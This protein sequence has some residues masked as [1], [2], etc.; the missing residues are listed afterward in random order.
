MVDLESEEQKM[1]EHEHAGEGQRATP[2][3]IAFQSLKTLSKDMKEHGVPDRIDRSVLTNFSGS[4]G[5]QIITA[6]KF[7]G[8]TKPDN[9]TTDRLKSLVDSY[10]TGAWSSNIADV[11][12]DA[13]SDIFKLNLE[14]AS[15]AQFTE[16]FRKTHPAKDDVLRKCITFFLNATREGNIPISAYIMKNKK[17]RSAPTKKR[18]GKSAGAR[19]SNSNQNTNQNNRDED[20]PPPNA[21][22]APYEVLLDILDPVEMDEAEQEAVWTLLKYLKKA[23]S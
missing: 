10:D 2:P 4:V 6:L 1:V 7:L 22:P 12:R 20:P 8:L 5:G 3:Y 17:P 23:K 13:Y 16:Y 19:N 21:P 11:T 15:P 9:S 14:T 18:V